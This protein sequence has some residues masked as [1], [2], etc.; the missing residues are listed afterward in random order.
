MWLQNDA[1]KLLSELIRV[2]TFK[3]TLHSLTLAKNLTLLE[4]W[5]SLDEA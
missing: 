2:C 3:N 5:N 1:L 4:A